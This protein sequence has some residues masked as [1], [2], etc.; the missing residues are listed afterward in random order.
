MPK[1]RNGL[2]ILAGG[3]CTMKPQITAILIS[4]FAAMLSTANPV[5]AAVRP[6]STLATTYSMNSNGSL[7]SFGKVGALLESDPTFQGNVVTRHI[8]VLDSASGTAKNGVTLYDYKRVDTILTASITTT[9]SRPRTLALP[10]S[11]G[12]AARPAMAAGGHFLYIATNLGTNVVQVQKSNLAQ[13]SIEITNVGGV[14]AIRSNSYG[15]V[16]VTGGSNSG[17]SD[18]GLFDPNGRMQ[19][20]GGGAQVAVDTRNA[21]IPADLPLY[22]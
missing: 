10:L 19:E 17:L 12:S 16:T 18:F 11:G 4:A 21:L 5:L 3:M 2:T 6:D 22:P 7:G 14:A 20:S 1:V 15:W 13:T 9:I 8:Y